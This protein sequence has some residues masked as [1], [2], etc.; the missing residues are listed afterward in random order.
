MLFLQMAFLAKFFAYFAVKYKLPQ[1]TQRVIAKN[2]N[3]IVY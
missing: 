2:A 3:I 1:R